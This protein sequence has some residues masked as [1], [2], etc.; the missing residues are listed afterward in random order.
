MKQTQTTQ[1][2]DDVILL[3]IFVVFILTQLFIQFIYELWHFNQ[4]NKKSVKLSDTNRLPTKKARSQQTPVSASTTL[5]NGMVGRTSSG[6]AIGIQSPPLKKSR[7]GSSTRSASHPM[8][9]KSNQTLQ[10][11][12]FQSLAWSDL[13]IGCLHKITNT[14]HVLAIVPIQDQNLSMF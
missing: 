1:Q 12:G 14:T 10:N 4:S 8:K 3:F 2:D 11:P 5:K 7:S 6:E 13:S 9:T